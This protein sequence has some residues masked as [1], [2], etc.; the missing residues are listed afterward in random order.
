MRQGTLI[1]AGNFELPDKNAAAHRVVNNAKL[2]KEPGFDTVFL[3]TCRGESFAGLKKREYG[4]GFD[5]FEQAYPQTTAQWAKSLTAVSGIKELA[6]AYP[7]TAAVILYNTQYSLVSA[8]RRALCG[9]GIKILYDC[10]EWN[11]FTLGNSV[12]RAVKKLD[13]VLIERAL[14]RVCDGIIAVSDTMVKRYSGKKPLVHLP[15][16][17][18]INDPIWRAEPF[19]NGVFTFC[20]AGDPADKDRLDLLTDAFSRIPAG[21]AALEVIGAEAPAGKLPAGVRFT[22]RLSHED[23]V[24][25]ILSCGCFIFLRESTR[26]NNAGFPTKFVEAYTC[27]VPVITTAVSDALRYAG[28]SCRVIKDLSPDTVFKAMTGALETGN[29]NAG[30]RNDFDHRR[31]AAPVKEFFDKL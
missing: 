1:Y 25:H 28:G 26:R 15:P 3:G 20:Y 18:D 27:G 6:G 22:G 21:K 13:S 4:I 16:L 9:T 24:R 11:G 14:P 5:V 17:V 7:D 10:T 2:F 31:Y 23:T 8:V 29:N 30:L 19:D 12:K